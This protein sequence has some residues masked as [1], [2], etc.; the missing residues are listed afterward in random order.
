[1]RYASLPTYAAR[2]GNTYLPLSRTAKKYAHSLLTK[3]DVSRFHLTYGFRRLSFYPFV[4]STCFSSSGM[5][6]ILVRLSQ[7]RTLSV[8]IS[9]KSRVLKL[10]TVRYN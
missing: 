9:Y 6:Y 2:Y 1:M 10:A 3:D 7:P 4:G 5:T 8:T